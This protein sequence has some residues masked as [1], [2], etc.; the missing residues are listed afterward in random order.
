MMYLYPFTNSYVE[1]AR[2]E[3]IPYLG[4]ADHST[5]MRL[6][7]DYVLRKIKEQ[8][9]NG[10]GVEFTG[11]VMLVGHWIQDFERAGLQVIEAL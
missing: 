1:V 5:N 3:K 11:N 10:L 8:L 6:E 7:I 2:Y 9:K 4:F